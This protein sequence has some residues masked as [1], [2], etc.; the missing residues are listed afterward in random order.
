MNQETGSQ[1]ITIPYRAASLILA[2]I[3]IWNARSQSDKYPFSIWCI[4]F[5]WMIL[6]VRLVDDTMF[7]MDLH[8]NPVNV[9]RN[10]TLILGSAIPITIAYI[11][12]YR[13]I[14]IEYLYKYCLIMLSVGAISSFLFNSDIYAMGYSVGTDT[15]RAGLIAMNPITFG[16]LGTALVLVTVFMKR[17]Y[18]FRY[19]TIVQ[20]ALLLIGLTLVAKAASRGPFGVLVLSLMIYLFIT[21]RKWGTIALF[22][23][24]V[25]IVLWPFIQGFVFNTFIKPI[26]PS[27]Y[28]RIMMTIEDGDAG[29][30]NLLSQAFTLF[31]E[32]PVF[33]TQFTLYKNGEFYYAHNIIVDSLVCGGIIGFIIFMIPLIRGCSNVPMLLRNHSLALITVICISQILSKLAS[34]CYF[35]GPQAG[36]A[37]SC[38][39][40]FR[41]YV[42]YS[43]VNKPK[44]LQHY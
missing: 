15:E 17:F 11:R 19:I 13:Q 33:G 40:L 42:D 39:V 32:S 43:V 25:F 9:S 23:G 26:A 31:K 37:I 28:L 7:R 30:A 1:F 10:V 38:L 34:G 22:V 35:L 44:P 41:K 12:S 6:L 16:H 2:I 24:C 27:L 3:V 21:N 18:N 8:L 14:S 4:A 29:R 5:Y 36:V 20:I